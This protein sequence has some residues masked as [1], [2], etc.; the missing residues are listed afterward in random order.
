MCS[1]GILPLNPGRCTHSIPRSNTT[2]SYPTGSDSWRGSTRGQGQLPGSPPRCSNHRECS[3]SGRARR[4]PE[5]RTATG[6]R[7]R[8]ETPERQ[9]EDRQNGSWHPSPLLKTGF[10]HV[11]TCSAI[12]GPDRSARWQTTTHPQPLARLLRGVGSSVRPPQNRT[13]ALP[14]CSRR[15]VAHRARTLGAD[16]WGGLVLTLRTGPSRS[17]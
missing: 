4:P 16:G 3:L 5:T 15:A 7:W 10:T 11:T 14:H 6:V 9:T 17:R 12:V 1:H 2:R 8:A 13:A